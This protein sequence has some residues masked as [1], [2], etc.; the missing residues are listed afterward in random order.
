MLLLILFYSG[1]LL[2]I[3]QAKNAIIV[4]TEKNT[5]GPKKFKIILDKIGLIKFDKEKIVQ[6]TPDSSPAFF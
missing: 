6:N 4:N 1:I 5:K 3:Q 2:K